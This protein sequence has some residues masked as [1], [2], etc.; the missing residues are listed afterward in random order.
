MS[1]SLHE[2]PIL[3]IGHFTLIHIESIYINRIH[4]F[5]SLH[6]R[7]NVGTEIA[8]QLL[9]SLLMNGAIAGLSVT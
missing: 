8:M 9:F 4:R 7:L 3:S 6:K 2:L 1:N 5:L